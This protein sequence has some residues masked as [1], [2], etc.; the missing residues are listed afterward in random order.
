M[1]TVGVIGGLVAVALGVMVACSSSGDDAAPATIEAG[2]G[3]DAD[4]PPAESGTD[5]GTT[6]DTNVQHAGTRIKLRGIETAEG[7]FIY[8]APFDSK[9]GTVCYPSRTE[10]GVLRCVP[11]VTASI[12]TFADGNCTTL[13]GERTKGACVKPTIGERFISSA[14]DPCDTRY[15]PYSLGAVVDVAKVYTKSNGVDCVQSD[16][17]PDS[18]YYAV[19]APIAPADLVTFTQSIV[20]LT[21]ELGAYV[22]DGDDGSRIQRSYFTD[23]KRGKAC[24]PNV[25]GDGQLRCTPRAKASANG[26]YGAFSDTACTASIAESAICT[27][28]YETFDDSTATTLDQVSCKPNVFRAFTLGAKR[29]SRDE[30]RSD[31]DGGCTGPLVGTRDVY[32]IGAEI[33]PA[34][35]P[36]F[37][38]TLGGGP[39]VVERTLV[40]GGVVAQHAS[41]FVSDT[42]LGTACNYATAADGKLRCLPSGIGASVYADDKCT[43]VL[44]A[45]VEDCGAVKYVLRSDETGGACN[46]VQHVHVPG[47][48]L[49]VATTPAF[50]RNG[51]NCMPIGGSNIIAY[52]TLGAE[53]PASTFAEGTVATK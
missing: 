22:L 34:S 9:L 20:P 48:K 33:A 17:S 44:G 52:Y 43:T 39:R 3:N 28:A 47:T 8:D 24:D 2:N 18:E 35:M 1:R 12:T 29:A 19:L 45:Q 13:L 30:Y 53:V 26:F 40:S 23:V 4:A 7:T 25:A 21:P 5:G 42:T 11:Q 16:A 38:V 50:Q 41:F 51:V 49:D 31:H 10:D 6:V 14:T 37:T 46:S 27:V 32:D 15:V 36:A